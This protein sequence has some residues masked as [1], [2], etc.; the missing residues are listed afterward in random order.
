MTTRRV[1]AG[2]GW[3]W[4]VGGWQLFLK[5]PGLWIVMLLIYFAINIAL[6]FIPIIGG[7]AE[8]LL[9]PALL[10]GMVYGAAALANGNDLEIQHLFRAFQDRDRLGPMLTLGALLLLGYVIIGLVVGGLILGWMAGGDMTGDMTKVDE[11]LLIRMLTGGGIVAVLILLLLA[12]VLTMAMFYAIPL[13]MLAKEAPLRS[14]Q[15]SVSACWINLWPLT[16]LSL[17]YVILAL[18]AAIP[19]GLGFLV[20]GPVTFSAIYASYKD[21]FAV[22]ETPQEPTPPALPPVQF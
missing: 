16:V 6:S 21:V 1:E 22:Q 14:L 8:A 9:T 18:L 12:I 20:L 7:V 5:A 15:E 3:Q 19:M 4:L 17:I 13:V 11:A 10:G 2:Q